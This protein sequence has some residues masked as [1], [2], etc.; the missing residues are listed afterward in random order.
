MRIVIIRN[1]HPN[2]VA[3]FVTARMFCDFLERRGY[4]VSL[5]TTPV[6][7]TEPLGLILGYMRGIYS[8]DDIQEF[9]DQKL[10]TDWLEEVK[11]LYGE[12]I[13]LNFHSQDQSLS[14]QWKS[15]LK[16]IDNQDR[17]NEIGI[18]TRSIYKPMKNQRILR[19]S[20]KVLPILYPHRNSQHLNGWYV[21]FVSDIQRCREKG[22]FDQESIEY[23][24]KILEPHINQ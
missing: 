8:L 23:I 17:S 11:R 4:D 12:S 18:E 15:Y 21:R 7:V 2:E 24:M 13:Y 5:E 16:R 19:A 10:F 20:E 3:A 9:G 1:E 6:L 14:Y 22:F